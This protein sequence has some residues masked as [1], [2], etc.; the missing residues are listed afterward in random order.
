MTFEESMARLDEIVSLLNSGKTTLD[1]SLTLYA[2]GTKL[3]SDCKK[4]LSEARVRIETLGKEEN[5]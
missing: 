5:A 4:Q 2:E 1:E 3:L